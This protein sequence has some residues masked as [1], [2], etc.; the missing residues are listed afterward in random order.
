MIYGKSMNENLIGSCGACGSEMYEYEVE[1]CPACG[2][3]VHKACL[4]VCKCGD[5]QADGCKACHDKGFCHEDCK[6]A[7]LETFRN[8]IRTDITYEENFAAFKDWWA[9]REELL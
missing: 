9:E 3:L 7:H 2:K 6:L 4:S 5:C 1:H 8:R